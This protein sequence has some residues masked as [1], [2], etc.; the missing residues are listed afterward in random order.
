MKPL[1]LRL[2]NKTLLFAVKFTCLK[3]HGYMQMCR[4]SGAETLLTPFHDY[5]DDQFKSIY[6]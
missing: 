2:R 1:T 4:S 6:A 3:D 5:Y